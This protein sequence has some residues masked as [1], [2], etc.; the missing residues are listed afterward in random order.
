[1]TANSSYYSSKISISSTEQHIYCFQ[2]LF[3]WFLRYSLLYLVLFNFTRPWHLYFNHF[4]IIIFP[5]FIYFVSSQL[6]LIYFTIFNKCSFTEQKEQLAV[7]G[8]H[9]FSSCE[10]NNPFFSFCPYSHCP[11]TRINIADPSNIMRDYKRRDSVFGAELFNVCLAVSISPLRATAGTI[12]GHEFLEFIRDASFDAKLLSSQI[13]SIQECYLTA[14]SV[15]HSK[16][17]SN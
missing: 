6:L 7:G 15:V 9:Y 14:G 3:S 4:S 12:H 5:P 17:N 1:M 10:Q 8:L 11:S 16:C 2:T 13:S